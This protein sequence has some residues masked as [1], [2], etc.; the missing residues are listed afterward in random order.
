MGKHGQPLH[1]TNKQITT[2]HTEILDCI[3]CVMVLLL[4]ADRGA[5]HCFVV[6]KYTKKIS[7]ISFTHNSPNSYG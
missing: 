1:E 5:D 4:N 6:D 7:V 3:P 2:K